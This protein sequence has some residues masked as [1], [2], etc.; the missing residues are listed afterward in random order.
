M[1]DGQD[2]E[3]RVVIKV[4]GPIFKLFKTNVSS[5]ATLFGNLQFYVS[6][7]LITIGLQSVR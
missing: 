4:A 3:I 7:S 1:E 2:K 5:S 6:L